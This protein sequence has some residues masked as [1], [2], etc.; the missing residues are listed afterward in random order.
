[1]KCKKYNAIISTRTCILRQEY[2]LKSI[3][4]REDELKCKLITNKCIGC[5]VGRVVKKYPFKRFDNDLKR[6][7]LKVEEHTNGI[8]TPINHNDLKWLVEKGIFYEINRKILHPM[9]FHISVKKDIITFLKT[10]KKEGFVLKEVDE[11]LIKIFINAMSN[12]SKSRFD[13]FLFVVQ[14]RDLNLNEI[15]K[16]K[17]K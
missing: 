8:P 2:L 15:P 1:M 4:S 7:K 16:E 12:K 9:G 3:L 10:T 14:D 11:D 6:L 5:L 13:N 17:Q